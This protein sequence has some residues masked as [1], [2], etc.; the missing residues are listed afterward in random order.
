MRMK[1]KQELIFTIMV[2][3][4]VMAM[5]AAGVAFVYWLIAISQEL[6]K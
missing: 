5:T 4:S 1:D 3:T 2:Y 6:P